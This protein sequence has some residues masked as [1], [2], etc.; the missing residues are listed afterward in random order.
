MNRQHLLSRLG[1]RF[2]ILYTNGCLNA[3]D[4]GKDV[5]RHASILGSMRQDSGVWVD[6]PSKLI[7][8]WP[9]FPGLDEAAIRVGA[10]RL[11]QLMRRIH[12]RVALAY[13]FHP[14][15][16]RSA[17]ALRADHL[18]YHAFDLF[19]KTEGWTDQWSQA[20]NW[21]LENAKLVFAS[22]D[23]IARQLRSKC[24][25][26]VIVIPNGVDYEAFSCGSVAERMELPADLEHIPH[27]LIG[28]VG[29]INQKVDLKLIADLA[30]ANRGWNF[31]FVGDVRGRDATT[32]VDLAACKKLPN[33]HF[34]GPKPHQDLPAYTNSMDVNIMCY[35]MDNNLWSSAGYPLKM[36]EYLATG[37]PVV[38]SPLET[39]LEF[40]G[41]LELATGVEQWQ[42]KLQSALDDNSAARIEARRAVAR[43][44]TWDN[45]VAVI[46]SHLAPLIS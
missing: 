23:P 16:L 42:D 1:D 3:W 41:V 14:R 43:A 32:R 18:V 20:E 15:H 40:Q 44:N 17:R 6:F 7:V 25:R 12:A 22:S 13:V 11:R 27:P 38:S 28:Y 31:I 24:Q 19:E 46:A 29:N 39:V 2:P 36:H 33:I 34:L 8:R 4:R 45:R 35:R 37:R 30:S 5:W 21:M 10:V 26:E 9:K